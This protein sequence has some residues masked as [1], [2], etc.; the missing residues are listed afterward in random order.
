MEELEPQIIEND[1]WLN[2]KPLAAFVYLF[3][4]I[5]DFVVMP[6]MVHQTNKDISEQLVHIQDQKEMQQKADILRMAKWEPL[7]MQNAG[8]FHI[9]FGT[10][11]T[12]AAVFGELRKRH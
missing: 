12:G 11:L 1:K 4:C 6:V 3:I 2:W 7:T 8:L 5:M 10:I 9:A